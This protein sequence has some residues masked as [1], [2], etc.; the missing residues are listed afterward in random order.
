MSDS[1]N[2]PNARKGQLKYG[3]QQVIVPYVEFE[4]DRGEVDTWLGNPLVEVNPKDIGAA[5]VKLY[6]VPD[7]SSFLL[8]GSQWGP[9]SLPPTLE[10]L[11][12]S[13]QTGGGST[14][15]NETGSAVGLTPSS[16]GLSLSGTAQASASVVPKIL[17]VVVDNSYDRVEFIHLFFMSTVVDKTTILARCTAIMGTAVTAWPLFKTRPVNLIVTGKKVSVSN[18]ATFQF[19]IS[20]GSS[21]GG[22]TSQTSGTGEGEDIDISVESVNIPATLHSA[23]TL[24]GSA[25]V[26]ETATTAITVTGSSPFGGTEGGTSTATATGTVSTTSVAATSPTALPTS[27]LN[28]YD[29]SFE[30]TLTFGSYLVHAVLFNFAQLA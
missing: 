23:F 27:T 12:V 28:L 9:I 30:P 11:S 18:R 13:Y 10:S 5:T 3:P 25:T 16:T 1:F 2:A 17:A 15:Y 7:L 26:T 6:S 22:A 4:V 19:N 20:I 29:L 21:G 8:K 14:N 24:S